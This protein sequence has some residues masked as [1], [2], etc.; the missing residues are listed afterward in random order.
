MKT[1][2]I[3]SLSILLTLMTLA[4]YGQNPKKTEMRSSL[5]RLSENVQVTPNAANSVSGNGTP[6]RLSKWTGVSGSNTYVL[7]DSG[8]FE[9]KF[10]KVGI[11]TITPT[12]PLTVA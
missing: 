8:I 9:D 10:G 2:K 12:S 3:F 7:G 6:G 5:S 11:G 1:I 4:A